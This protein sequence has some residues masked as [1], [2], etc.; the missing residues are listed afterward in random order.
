MAAHA[1]HCSRH[2]EFGLPIAQLPI[3]SRRHT[4]RLW[5]KVLHQT[6]ASFH[7]SEILELRTFLIGSH[8]PLP[9][10]VQTTDQE[11]DEK[12]EI[13]TICRPL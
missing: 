12:E 8:V 5:T 2:I 4:V 9:E 7:Y 10:Y 11:F 1:E 3:Q 13:Q 6:R